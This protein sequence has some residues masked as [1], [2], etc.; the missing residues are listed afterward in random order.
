M[1]VII[2][3]NGAA[4]N[5][6]AETL[7]QISPDVQI[8]IYAGDAEPFYSACALPDFLAG[9]IPRRQLFLKTP[10]QY[11]RQGIELNSSEWVN[12]IDIDAKEICTTRNT[13][14]YD[15]LILATGSRPL[16]PPVPGSNL[17]GNFVVK[18][19]RD[20]DRLLEKRP[21][22]AVVVGSGNIGVEV[23]EALELKGCEAT[24]IEMQQRILPRLFDPYPAGLIQ[25]LL[26]AHR[27]KVMTGE[28]VL[29]VTGKEEAQGVVTGSGPISCETVIWAA[30]AKP[31]IDLA[32]AAGLRI[33][34]RGAIKVDSHMCSSHPDIY[35]CGDCVEVIDILS[36]K[37]TQS[38][39]WSSAKIQAQVAARN[40]M[41]QTV[42][43]PGAF[44]LMVEELYGVP[45]LAAGIR[46]E[47]LPDG[48][49]VIELNEKGAYSRIILQDGR[50]AGL[51]TV[52]TLD[53]CGAIIALMKKHTGVDEI[54]RSIAAPYMREKMP[55]LL[56]VERRL[57]A[58]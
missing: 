26:E 28:Q 29:E 16:V 55:W 39:L 36:G 34:D 22:R 1:K 2:I 25:K 17:P 5:Q 31:N 45:C 54:K 50:I 49:S 13:I 51:Q 3:G 57:S 23:A 21:R 7:R 47:E 12:K 44:N 41:G 24:I 15:H 11:A 43:Y 18:R 35:A 52:G 8:S 9:W 56:E 40:I 32:L 33:G 58:Q 38:M 46:G 19:P 6:A 14:K 42:E 37:P 30:G 20:I 48:N 53:A 4:G 10:E 27:I